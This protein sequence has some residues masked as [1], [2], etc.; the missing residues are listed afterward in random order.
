MWWLSV[1]T[2]TGQIGDL[3]ARWDHLRQAIM[4]A[5]SCGPVAL[6]T[7][8]HVMLCWPLVYIMLCLAPAPGV[9]DKHR[10]RILLLDSQ[11]DM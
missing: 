3:Y 11:I 9:R 5:V 10:F 1:P 8:L 7:C 4:N 2:S 6:C